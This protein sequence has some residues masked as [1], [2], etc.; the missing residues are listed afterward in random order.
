MPTTHPESER[1]LTYLID[2]FCEGD[3][4]ELSRLTG[5][6][7][8]WIDKILRRDH[9]ITFTVLTDILIHLGVRNLNEL[10]FEIGKP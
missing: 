6:K 7:K 1:I 9:G 4:N 10:D 5:K 8:E 2:T 3:R